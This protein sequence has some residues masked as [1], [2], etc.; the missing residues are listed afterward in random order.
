MMSVRT[1]V[2]TVSIS[3][4]AASYSSAEI[5]ALKD[6]LEPHAGLGLDPVSMP[7]S[8][9]VC[10]LWATIAFAEPAL[11]G[12]AIASPVHEAL[13]AVCGEL[14]DWCRECAAQRV[15]EPEVVAIHLEFADLRLAFD[16]ESEAGAYLSR[17]EIR[18]IPGLLREMAPRLM[19]FVS[20]AGD[21]AISAGIR[22]N[23]NEAGV[24]RC[25]PARY[26]QIGRAHEDP[27]II[28]DSWRDWVYRRTAPIGLDR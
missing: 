22:A 1:C 3:Y 24:V 15:D 6:R 17:A 26:W 7:H 10:E 25:S 13:S 9:G 2:P 18:A 11:V 19:P 21:T 16:S 14:G 12:G 5:E 28:Y 4:E 23:R 8:S 27:D 20:A